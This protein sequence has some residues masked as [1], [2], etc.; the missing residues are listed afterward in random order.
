VGELRGFDSY[1]EK[2]I[3]RILRQFYLSLAPE[4]ML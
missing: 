1:E 4:E 2:K 3:N